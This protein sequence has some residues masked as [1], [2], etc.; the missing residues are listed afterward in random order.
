MNEVDKEVD[1]LFYYVAP[2]VRGEFCRQLKVRGVDTLDKVRRLKL[3]EVAKWNRVGEKKLAMLAKM[4]AIDDRPKRE[5]MTEAERRG[6]LERMCV[7][8]YTCLVM[9]SHGMCGEGCPH[10]GRDEHGDSKCKMP[11]FEERMKELGLFS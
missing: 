11:H 9:S 6:K 10:Y 4:G 3:S 1:R 5:G 2:N 8:L 7:D